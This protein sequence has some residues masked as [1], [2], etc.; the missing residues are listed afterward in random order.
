MSVVDILNNDINI[1]NQINVPVSLA[2]Q[3]IHPIQMVVNDLTAVKDALNNL[4]SQNQQEIPEV[5]SE[6]ILGSTE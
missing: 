5:S 1:L 4:F 3:V 6:E 2:D